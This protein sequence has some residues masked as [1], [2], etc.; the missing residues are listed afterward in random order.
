MPFAQVVAG[1]LEQRDGTGPHP[2]PR[3]SV[4]AGALEQCD[5]R[6]GEWVEDE[7][8]PGAEYGLRALG[9]NRGDGEL[10][11]QDGERLC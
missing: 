7:D 6:D 9:G 1:A 8:E 4:V 11:E 3:P 10:G 2:H 5:E